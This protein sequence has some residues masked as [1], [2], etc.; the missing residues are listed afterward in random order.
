VALREDRKSERGFGLI[1]IVVSMFLL[2]ILTI[3][4]LPLLVQSLQTSARNNLTATASQLLSAQLDELAAVAPY[5]DEVTDFA[6]G[7]PASVTDDRGNSYQA[8]RE[9]VACPDASA[10]GNNYPGV[11]EVTV[12]VAEGPTAAGFTCESGPALA[13]ATTLVFLENATAPAP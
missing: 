3:A 13:T 5:C 9:V 7:V 2:A 6:G 4:F 10:A 11:V 8:R 12:C 1:E